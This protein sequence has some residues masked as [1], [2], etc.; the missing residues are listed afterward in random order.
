[1]KVKLARDLNVGDKIEFN[2]SDFIVKNKITD[3]NTGDIKLEL[4]HN[5]LW[6][7]VKSDSTIIVK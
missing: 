3:S 2:D 5:V 6:Y 7:T 1:M 4:V